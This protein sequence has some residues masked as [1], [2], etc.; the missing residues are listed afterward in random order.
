MLTQALPAA[1]GQRYRISLWCKGKQ[2][3]PK[4][5]T[6]LIDEQSDHPALVLPSGDNDWQQVT[7]E[8]EVPATE[9]DGRLRNVRV[10]IVSTA[11]GTVWLDDVKIK[12]VAD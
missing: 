12:R 6:V 11:P 1:T 9:G 4:G 10:Q 7:G 5:F 8:F 2:V 3:T